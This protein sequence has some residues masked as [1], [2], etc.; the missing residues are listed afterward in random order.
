MVSVSPTRYQRFLS[1][2]VGLILAVVPTGFAQVFFSDFNSGVPAGASIPP[3][4]AGD[5]N[6]ARVDGG[7]LKLTDAINSSGGIFYIDDFGAGR[8]VKRFTATFK[9]YLFGSVCCGTAGSLPADGFSFNLAPAAS[10]LANPAYGQPAEEGLDSG[11][12]VNFDT[13]D[14]GGGEAPAIEVKWLG[15]VVKRA[16]IHPSQSPAGATTPAQAERK[17]TINLDEDGTID[18]IYGNAVICENVPTPYD[19]SVIGTPKWVLGARTGGA[20][21]NHWIDDLKIVTAPVSQLVIAPQ[22]SEW[23]YNESTLSGTSLHGT[24]W[25]LPNYNTNSAPGWKTGMSLFGNDAEGV[26]NGPGQPFSGGIAGFLTPLD[27]NNG[28]VTFYLRTKFN[29]SG[30][31]AGVTLTTSNWVDDGLI[32]YLNGTEVSRIRIADGPVTWDTLGSNPP[33]EG[34]VEVRTWSAAS[35]VQGENTLAVEVHQSSTTSSDVA[36]AL[37]LQATGPLS[38]TITDPFQPSNRVVLANRATT[39]SV[40]VVASPAPSFQ[41]YKNGAEIPG[42]TGPTFDIP[43][44]Q[45]SDEGDYFVRIS[46]PVGTVD[47]RTAQV[48]YNF[49]ETAPMVTEV[50]GSASF[51]KVIVSFNEL[52]ETASAIDSFNY[53]ITDSGGAPL[54]VNGAELNANGSSVTLTTDPQTPDTLYTLTVIL[55][56]DPAGN[57]ITSVSA[58]FRS[59]VPGPCNGVVFE[60]FNV[61]NRLGIDDLLTNQPN[62]PNNP[63]ERMLLTGFDSRLAYSDDS[64]EDYAGRMT[65][66]FIPPSSGNYIFHIRSDDPG[67]LY[68]N[69][70]GPSATGKIQVANEAGC[71]NAFLPLGAAQTSRAFPMEAGKGYYVELLWREFTGGDYGQVAV[72]LQGQPTPATVNL[73]GGLAGAGAAPAGVG[74]ALNITQQPANVSTLANMVASFTVQAANVNGLPICYQWRRNGTDIPG[75]SLA[76]YSF[77]PVSVAADDGAVFDVR[78]SVLGATTL[79]SQATLRVSEDTTRPTIASVSGSTDLKRVVVVFSEFV[80]ATTANDPFNFT[81]NSSIMVNSS[82]LG[83][84]QKTV[85]LQ[86]ADAL[87]PDTAYTLNAQLV[88]DLSGNVMDNA[89]VPFR[90]FALVPGFSLAEL[91]MNLGGGVALTDLTGSPK[92]PSSPD[93]VRYKGLFEL[94]TFDEFESYGARMSGFLVPPVSGNYNFYMSSDD[95]GA[96]YLSTDM[97]PANLV[98]VAAEPVWNGRRDWLGTTR[99]NAAA[100]ENR[101][102]TL[103]PG[104]ISLVA[105]QKYYFEALVKEG[106]GGDNLAVNWQLPGAAEPLTGSTPISGVYMATLANPAGAQLQITQQPADQTFII[107]ADTLLSESFNSGNGGFAVSTPEAFNTPWTY[108]AG[109]G[110][111]VVNQDGA[112]VNHPMTSLLTGPE[113]TVTKAGSVTLRFSHR[114]SFEFDGTRWDGGAVQISVNGGA[115]VAVPAASFTQNGYG[116]NS[117]AGNSRSALAGQP[118][119]TAESAGHTAGTLITTIAALGNFT[120]GDKVQIRFIYAGDTN[121]RGANVPNWQI[122][123]VQV[124][125]G[126]GAAQSVTFTVGYQ[127]S[128]VGETTPTTFIQWFRDNGSGFQI[129]PG[130]NN[131]S[132]TFTPVLADNGAKFRAQVFILG[133]NETSAAATLSVA[134]PNTAPKFVAGPNQTVLEDAGPQTVANWATGISPSSLNRAPVTYQND[135]S[136]GLAGMEAFGTAVVEGGVLKLT[137][138]VNSVSG[139]ASISSAAQTYENMNVAWRSYIG[140][141]MVGGADGYSLNVGTDVPA[142]PGYGGEEGIGTGLS[143]TIDT[144]DNGGG[145]VGLEVKYGGARLAFL[146]VAKDN[147]GSGNYLR[148][149]AFVDASV[150]VSPAGLATFNYDGNIV[151]AQLPNYAGLRA[152]RA[153]FWA[154]TGNA[155]DNHWIDDFSFAG[156][157]YDSSSVENGQ[158]VHFNVSNNNPSLFIVQPA[159]SASGTLTYT[160]APNANGVATVTVVAMDDG[161][162][163]NGGSDTS[164]AQVFTITITPAN[165]CPTLASL[166]PLTVVSGG[167]VSAQLVGSDVDGDVLQYSITAPP[168]HGTVT[169]QLATG[170]LTYAPVAGYIGPDSFRAAVTDAAGCRSGE[171][172]VSVNVTEVNRCPT[173][174]AKVQ[175]NIQLSPGQA[176]TIVISS[177]GTNGC[178]TLD[179]SQSSDPDGDTLAYSWVLVSGGGTIPIASGAHATACLEVGSYT[180]RLIVDDGRCIKTADV[181]VEI[182]TASEAIDA[183]IEKVNDA[184]IDRKNKRPFIAS[185]KAASASFD[186][187]SCN[188]GENQ[189][190]AFINKVRAQVARNNPA[191]A[192]DLIATANAILAQIDC[193]EN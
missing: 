98:Q 46:N 96:F 190:G 121:T 175:P 92:Y 180:V 173:A 128:K 188:S 9:A 172:T 32:A 132:L 61:N 42:A 186:R 174:V 62:F 131:A 57:A 8:P 16:S 146:A 6:E 31:T 24:G 25:E 178:L 58:Q 37:A 127:A 41:W 27:R 48:R 81:V 28:R 21:D 84:D 191:I 111:W 45:I 38:P 183:L 95:N 94:N 192:A 97:N 101:S 4:P 147:D 187:G 122:D 54:A 182:I 160:P 22:G 106:G 123:S 72:S 17:V 152:D 169:L 168:S 141:G 105:G 148:K 77:G 75:A 23:A 185:L 114:Y 164:A 110:S 137:T 177:N 90:S 76:T 181:V 65:G 115:F 117:V 163:A 189:L 179:G 170:A 69:P 161:G 88:K 155:N 53:S 52:L 193:P 63:R 104:G 143:V 15:T 56:K 91:Y 100:P 87:T 119:F 107:A 166:G 140:D 176:E 149:S 85:T 5:A 167:S 60:T 29:W 55:V 1:T 124:N 86:L 2:I 157:L 139:A 130:A 12:A 151:S 39:L 26:Y 109:L 133:A 59:W 20:N 44:M 79:S 11:L 116:G 10:V 70:T 40:G 153:L 102:T 145:E 125:Q 13:W 156:F 108:D 43:V 93:L 165:D 36:F 14:N 120:V 136:G 112:E 3:G 83:A 19:A 7:Y 47:S 35:L 82:T 103:F 184:N 30:S 134:T 154:R 118:A 80:D 144:W 50:I 159:V 34:V 162:T 171:I 68:I 158:T 135:F 138:P 64:H 66:L 49:D 67:R 51:D 99:R 18:V 113:L 71:C 74:G 73:L 33:T 78:V 89:N 150:T 129:V 142:N 126:G